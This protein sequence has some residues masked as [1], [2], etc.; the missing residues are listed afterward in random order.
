MD[1]KPLNLVRPEVPVELAAVVAKMMAKEPERRFQEPK[2]VA[3]A[4]IPFFKEG[5]ARAG[6]FEGLKLSQAAGGGPV[7]TAPTAPIQPAAHAASAHV[8][9]IVKPADGT[10]TGSPLRDLIQINE[11]ESIAEKP[12]PAAKWEWRKAGRFWPAAIAASLLGISSPALVIYRIGDKGDTQS[13][14]SRKDSPIN[15]KVSPSERIVDRV[16]KSTRLIEVEKPPGASSPDTASLP[17]GWPPSRI[18]RQSR[19]KIVSLKK[20]RPKRRPLSPRR[21]LQNLCDQHPPEPRR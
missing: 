18:A 7:G 16:E 9:P 1:A 3:Q 12:T 10:Q 8:T 20:G 15:P 6:G 21:V 14:A 4:L 11:T 19:G 17:T 13:Q 2:E 5:G